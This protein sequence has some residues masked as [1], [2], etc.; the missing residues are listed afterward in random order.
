MTLKKRL[1]ELNKVLQADENK[2][3]A[4]QINFDYKI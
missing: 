4:D 3:E 1:K 2:L